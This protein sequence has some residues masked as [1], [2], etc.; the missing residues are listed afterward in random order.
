MPCKLL[1]R[2]PRLPAC[3]LRKGDHHP[4]R[5]MLDMASV[6][7]RERN[8][9]RLAPHTGNRLRPSCDDIRMDV[10]LL[11]EAARTRPGGYNR[12]PWLARAASCSAKCGSSRT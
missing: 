10:T 5:L 9:G 2:D 4:A 12:A 11:D 3:T 1:L 8:V 7:H 6:C